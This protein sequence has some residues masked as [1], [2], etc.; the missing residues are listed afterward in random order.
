MKLGQGHKENGFPPCQLTIICK[1][2]M[3]NDVQNMSVLTNKIFPE[4]RYVSKTLY[5]FYVCFPELY[6]TS[7][8]LRKEEELHTVCLFKEN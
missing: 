4:G 2:Q 8:Q 6:T 7:F 1:A 5:D 3:L